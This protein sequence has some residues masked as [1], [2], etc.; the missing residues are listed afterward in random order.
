MKDTINSDYTK[1][2]FRKLFHISSIL[3]LPVAYIFLT[4]HQMLMIVVPFCLLVIATDYFRHRVHFIG[5]IFNKIFGNLLREKESE[6]N[7]WTGSSYM[8]ISAL[9]VFVISPKIVAICAFSILAISDGLAALVGKRIVSKPFFEKSVAGSIAFGVSA[10]II[11]ITCGILTNQ[12]FGYYLFGIFAVCA[13]TII[14]ARPSFFNVDD[15]LT[16]P[17]MFAGIMTFF[18]FVWGINY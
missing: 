13:T 2:V 10:F 17:L 7:S 18:G 4:K 1:E 16:I 8:A 5:V 11:L 15:N 12:T 3:I 9:L 6:E 14:E